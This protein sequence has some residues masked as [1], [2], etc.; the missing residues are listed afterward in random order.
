VTS[1]SQQRAPLIGITTYGRDE[2]NEF[3]L[4]A[5]YVDA[6]RRA[7]GI[8]VLMAPGESRIAA[9]LATV[10]ALILAGGGDLDPHAYGGA[11]HATIYML[12]AE[13]DASE[14]QFAL[15][16]AD[17][18]LPVLCICRGAQ[19]L[20]VALGGTLYEHIPDEFGDTVTHRQPPRE[21]IPHE[22]T[23]QKG[24]RL[25]DL[26]GAETFSSVSWHHQAVRELGRGLTAVAFASDGVI[27]AI[28]L[29]GRPDLVAVQWHP[30]LSAAE[31]PRQQGL[32]NWL[33]ECA[34]RSNSSGE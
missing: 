10:D 25:A 24:S 5:E 19:V 30:E 2:K 12:D 8:P 9:W 26:M 20:N 31:D 22:V 11:E 18:T 17:S 7:G 15:D 13:R 3:H 21:P 32:F 33:V 1:H 29:E 14:M 27:E 23:V 4:P 6:V 34:R 28:E 16:I